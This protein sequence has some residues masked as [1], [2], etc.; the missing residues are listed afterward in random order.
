MS[1]CYMPRDHFTRHVV[2]ISDDTDES[3]AEETQKVK[4]ILRLVALFIAE[5]VEMETKHSLAHTQN[6]RMS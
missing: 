4:F 5:N 6:Y 2:V 3:L 1:K